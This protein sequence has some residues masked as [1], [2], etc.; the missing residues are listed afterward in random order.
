MTRLPGEPCW[1]E[2]FTPDT[3][4]AADFYGQLFGWTAT[5]PDE[6]H[7]GYRILEREG[8]PVAGL[9]RNDGSMGGPSTWSVYLA[10]DDAAGLVERARA[11]GAEVVAGPMVVGDLGS[12][13]VLVDPSGALVGAWEAASF[14]GTAAVAQDGAPVWFE[15]LSK[16]YDTSV[17]FYTDVFGWDPHTMSDTPELRYT[18][19]GKDE[20][21]RAG[22]MDATAM[23]GEQPSRWQF[24]LQVADTDDTVARATGAGGTVVMPPEDTPYGRLAVLKDPAGVQFCLM[25]VPAQ[26]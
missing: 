6:E 4:A 26:S 23:L 15:T 18:T 19:L 5:D 14:E 3:D 20:Q 12:M 21:A 2:L 16:D 25:G 17:R 7:G 1:I 22:I 13:A 24:Y 10:T 9:M 11:A 8:V